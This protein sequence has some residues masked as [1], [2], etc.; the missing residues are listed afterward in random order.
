MELDHLLNNNIRTNNTEILITSVEEMQA[1]KKE[2]IRTSNIQNV[3]EDIDST[4]RIEND[5]IDTQFSMREYVQMVKDVG[6]YENVKIAP[7]VMFEY[8]KG[9][10]LETE[11]EVLN[12]R[13][14]NVQKV[15][16][17]SKHT[18]QHVLTDQNAIYATEVIKEQE[19]YAI[20]IR[21]YVLQADVDIF[22][23]K[24]ENKIGYFK[25][26]SEYP[27]VMPQDVVDKLKDVQSKNIFDEFW[28]LYL[29]YSKQNLESTNSKV[30]KIEKDP[31]LFAKTI[32]E[33]DKLYY[34][35]DW[36][37][38][39]CDLT[40]DKFIDK[41]HTINKEYQPNIISD[42]TPA[43]VKEMTTLYKSNK[44]ALRNARRNSQT[45]ISILNKIRGW[46]RK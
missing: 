16:E 21:K 18:G 7:K 10:L 33:S 23:R 43:T 35:C 19:A 30:K 24:I 6:K 44:N 39:Y 22:L 42:I 34:I 9:N 45:E 26:L 13:L 29:D 1:I 5:E 17:Y 11:L 28:V 31:I 27:R 38:E 20:G 40:L 4:V 12:T 32:T 3:I 41:M 14:Q 25:L 46:F 15:F 37:D 2:L 8:L 36:I